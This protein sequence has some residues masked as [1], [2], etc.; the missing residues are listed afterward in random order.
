MK[1]YTR[2]EL[3]GLA[4]EATTEP[5]CYFMKDEEGKILYIGKA[6]NLKNRIT[7][8][9]QSPVHEVLRTE[10]MVRQVSHFETLLTKTE[11][12]ALILEVTLIK[13]H[14]PK[15][16]VMLKDDKTYPYIK[17]QLNDAYPRLEWT[18]KILKDGARY[19]GPF[20]S[21]WSARQVMKMLTESLKLRDCSDNTFSH[22]SRACILYQMEKCSAPCVKKIT[23]EDYVET[24]RHAAAVLEGKDREIIKEL[25]QKMKAASEMEE[26]E[27][28]A[29][30]RDQI[31]NLRM[32][33]ELQGVQQSGK[34]SDQ[35]VIYIARKNADSHGVILLIRGGKLQ[36]VKH[37]SFKNSDDGVTD[38]EMLSQFLTQHYS[39]GGEESAFP[40]AQGNQRSILVQEEL[41]DSI[42]ISETLDLKIKTPRTEV[43]KRLMS[44]AKT[45]GEHAL[46]LAVKKFEGHGVAALEE[47][48]DKLNLS[49]LPVRIECYDI[50]NISGEDAVASRV[51]FIDG[52]PEKNLYRKYKI[53]TV[54][55]SNDF[56]MM[57]EVLGRRFARADD[58]FPSLVVVDGGKGQLAQA[59]AILEELNIQGV[60]VVGLAKARTEKDFQAT[61]V[62]TSLER[63]FLPGRKNPVMLL[64]HTLSCKLLSHVRDE[65]HR[66][67][68]TY[69]R[70]VRDSSRQ[71]N[72]HNE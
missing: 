54:E 6:K 24:V 21:G 1:K 67:A 29:V 38:Q 9:F 47:V 37:Y 64:P 65:A 27:Q 39:E 16:N 41:P 17:I 43:E 60:P 23:R 35:D 53:K 7:S 5:G 26:F 66:F 31:E 55:G 40:I 44:V 48:Q 62:K 18:R 46:E 19:Y 10:L 52:A 68:I 50:S 63:V 34:D 20:P 32:V 15:Y 3:L 69:H 2:E 33:T 57:K 8:Y 61:E 59:V 56:A 12:E 70:K 58:P 36:S 72:D 51:V 22:R 49:E 71:G 45:N 14:K 11:A 13:K 42:L 25:K 28:A 4:R 30:I